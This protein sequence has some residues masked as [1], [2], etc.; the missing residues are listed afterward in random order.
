MAEY[1]IELKDLE[2]SGIPEGADN[3]T[4][5]GLLKQ[6]INMPSSNEGITYDKMRKICDISDKIDKAMENG[7]ILRLDADEHRLL[8]ERTRQFPFGVADRALIIFVD[9]VLD[10][11]KVVEDK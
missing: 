2:L 1:E 4:Y 3:P 8:K 9:D 7:N 5:G 6:I 11:K 10:A